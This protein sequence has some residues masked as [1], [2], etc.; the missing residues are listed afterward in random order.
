MMIFFALLPLLIGEGVGDYCP[1]RDP[2]EVDEHICR[3]NRESLP[4]IGIGTFCLKGHTCTEAVEYAVKVGYR[5][6][7]TA[8]V[9]D[10]FTA[11]AEVLQRRGRRY[12]YIESKVWPNHQSA[13]ELRKDLEFTLERLGTSYLDA[14]FLHWPNCQIPIEETLLAMEELRFLRK[15]RHIGLC[16]VT[17]SHLRRACEVGV[18][19]TWVQVEMHPFFCDWEL[20]EFCRERSITVQAW[21]PLG[22]GRLSRDPML[23][24]IGA[25]YK[26][27]AAQV[28][29]R[30]I[31]QHGCVPLP[32]SRNK[33]H[34]RENI[35][36]ADFVLTS[37]E[38][39]EIDRRTRSRHRERLCDTVAG[40]CDEFDF[41]WED[42][43][44]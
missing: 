22:R 9:F 4:L 8:T 19:I 6:I 27:T 7:D 21:A 14:Y 44:P 29:I 30:W 38:M 40:F 26:K 18:R 43:W 1:I 42:C 16:N 10:N 23:T 20:L 32:C 37:E 31:I 36:V 17:S 35:D 2:F 34:I 13:R 5:I 12:F 3:I 24:R 41:S 25:K 15:I 39:N 33:R 11:I 28:A